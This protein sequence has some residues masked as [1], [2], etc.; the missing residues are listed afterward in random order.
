MTSAS[1][2]SLTERAIALMT[3]PSVPAPEGVAQLSAMLQRIPDA[4]LA[5]AAS[6][7]LDLA[8]FM[9]TEMQ[10]PGAAA[11]LL[12]VFRSDLPRMQRLAAVDDA[13]KAAVT[14]G[15]EAAKTTGAVAAS[16]LPLSARG[17]AP[18]GTTKGDPMARFRLQ[19]KK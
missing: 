5:G 9:G 12:E 4:G 16:N 15:A 11:L 2:E 3:D 14:R 17:D 19:Q 6:Q 1:A 13:M 18:A 7:L 8:Y 10:Q